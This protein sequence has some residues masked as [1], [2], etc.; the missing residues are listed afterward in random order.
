[1]ANVGNW[2][3]YMPSSVFEQSLGPRVT[4]GE[5]GSY[6]IHNWQLSLLVRC[7]WQVHELLLSRTAELYASWASRVY[8]QY[9]YSINS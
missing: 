3:Y 6:S 8:I 2:A 4:F 5:A 1:M 7:S 9:Q